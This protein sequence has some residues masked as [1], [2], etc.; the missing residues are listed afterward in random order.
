MFLI[1]KG[2]LKMPKG[3]EKQ[4]GRKGCVRDTTAA[5]LH[6]L[7]QLDFLFC[8]FISHVVVAFVFN[9]LFRGECVVMREDE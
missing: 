6:L 1:V 3:Y 2:I 5:G 7:P 9:N 4:R 8:S